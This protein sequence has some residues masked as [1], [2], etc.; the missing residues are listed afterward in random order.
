[1]KP[2]Y[3]KLIFLALIPVLFISAIA[4]AQKTKPFKGIVTYSISYSGDIDAMTLA[5]M[6]KVMTLKIIGKM[7]RMQRSSGPGGFEIITNG[8]KKEVI[9]LIDMMEDKIY[10]KLLTA[11]IDEIVN[12]SGIYEIKY[13]EETKLI[14]GYT[15]HKAEYYTKSEDGDEQTTVVYYSEE[16]GGEELNYGGQFHGL[17]GLPLAWETTQDGITE[18]VEANLVKKGK[19]K[20]TDFMIPVDYREL[21]EDEKAALKEMMNAEE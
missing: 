5:Q 12:K 16:L 13:L 1:M 17:K 7:S 8:E 6:P 14:A 4:N 3:L 10:F 2:N 9:Y 15:C 19:V 18:V 20:S 21:T 11:E